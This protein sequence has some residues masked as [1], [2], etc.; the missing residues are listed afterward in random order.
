[1]AVLLVIAYHAWPGAVPRGFFGVDIFFVISGFLMSRIILGGLVDGSFTT[2]KFLRRRARRLVPAMLT[3]LAGTTILSAALLTAAQ[4]RDYLLQLVGALTLTANMFLWRQ[5]GYFDME[6]EVR[7]LLHFWSLAVEEQFYLL[8]PLTLL[9][10]S[11]R[12]RMPAMMLGGLVSVGLFL[13]SMHSGRFVG[14]AFYA[15]PTR[16]WELL[17]GAMTAWLMMRHPKLRVRPW[18]KQMAVTALL[19]LGVGFL[20]TDRA[21]LLAVAGTAVLLVGQD[22]WLPSNMAT[23]ALSRIGDISYSLYLVHWPLL[24]F[25]SNIYAGSPPDWTIL[26]VVLLASVLAAV[27]YR[28]V[29][30]PFRSTSSKRRAFGLLAVACICLMGM[31]IVARASRSAH[32]P[33]PPTPAFVYGLGQNCAVGSDP[34]TVS[35]CQTSRWP[36]VAIWGDSFAMHV[37]PGL[38]TSPAIAGSLAQLTLATCAPVA[39]FARPSGGTGS[40]AGGVGCLTFNQQVHRHLV[41]NPYLQVVV[42]SG[43][44]DFLRKDIPEDD[45]TTYGVRPLSGEARLAALVATVR[46]LQVGGKMVFLVGPTPSYEHNRSDAALCNTRELESLPVAPSCT[47][48]LSGAM[49]RAPFVTPALRRVAAQTGATLFLLQDVLCKGDAC[50]TREGRVLLY[51]DRNHLSHRGSELVMRR[52]GLPQAIEAVLHARQR[53]ARECSQLSPVEVALPPSEESFAAPSTWQCPPK[54]KG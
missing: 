47:V 54:P 11:P 31:G 40:D 46:A 6:L 2:S 34:R 1:M 33:A 15:L 26:S 36:R 22:D 42:L 25:S 16:L 50:E 30:K 45:L 21:Q 35:T 29:E 52:L 49:R 53:T 13:W 12:L 32:Q 14:L 28:F 37:V 18:L 17:V 48:S 23:A 51:R 39:G 4:W 27:Q 20:S 7:P 43:T 10:L 44:W 38:M 5:G 24:A 3:T 9:L 41:E 19:A 8:F